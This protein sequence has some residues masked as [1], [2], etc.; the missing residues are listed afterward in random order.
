MLRQQAEELNGVLEN[1]KKRISEL[2][3]KT[4]SQDA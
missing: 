1:I 4:E 3:T 2:E